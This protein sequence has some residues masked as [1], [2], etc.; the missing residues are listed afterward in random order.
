LRFIDRIQFSLKI[1]LLIAAVFFLSPARFASP[2]EDVLR[3]TPSIA[4][5]E[6]EVYPEPA[7]LLP[8]EP[9]PD[10]DQ[11]AAQDA[12]REAVRQELATKIQAVLNRPQ[13]R[14]TQ[15][16]I[17][18]YSIEEDRP[19]FSLNESSF[20]SPASNVKVFTT[21]TALDRLGRN[22]R[23]KTQILHTGELAP[24]GQLNGNLIIIGHGDPDLSN[25]ISADPNVYSHLDQIA[26]EIKR[27]GILS[28]HGDVIGDDSYFV[29]APYGRGWLSSDL[30][31]IYGA[32][33]SALSF[34]NNVLAVTA[35]P[36]KV[37]QRATVFTY[38]A[39]SM[40]HITNRSTTVA[41]KAANT[42]GWSHTPGTN[43]IRV[44]GRMP[45]NQKGSV[46][47]FNV[48]DPALY[49]ATILKERLKKAGVEISG[50]ARSRHSGEAP[51]PLMHPIYTH[52]SIPLADVVSFINKKSQNLSAEILL[53]TI[54]AEL[55][56]I[57]T[58]QA[59]LDVVEAFLERA[60]V[61]AGT[62][63]LYDGSGLSRN[64]LITPQAETMLLR[65]M[66]T[67]PSFPDFISSLPVSAYDGTLKGRM[68][69]SSAAGRV[70]GKTGTLKNVATLGGYIKTTSGQT[71]AFSIMA[72]NA[73]ETGAARQATDKICEILIGY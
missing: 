28:V 11:V 44:F 42:F 6:A 60:G 61:E 30:T 23:F 39:R 40:F 29:H 25:T 38:P 43:E 51:L 34:Y 62:V 45:S 65:Y 19:V 69:R 12:L 5:L 2:V 36:G 63:N 71:L 55:K 32:Q 16:G 1:P 66:A 18:I 53:R 37:G 68:H 56:G 15:W 67:R 57:G 52:E 3:D 47:Y 26:E 70:F 46:R 22:F 73:V 41:A 54:G 48:E 17:D 50:K 10:P 31:R 72:N 9:E 24:N 58:D 8:P 4:L 59:G 35:R 49:T 7:V 33:V 13:Y 27:A 21:A 14:N 20:F 64:N